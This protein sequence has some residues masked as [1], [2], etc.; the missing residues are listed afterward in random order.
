MA[1]GGYEAASFAI[2]AAW[3]GWRTGWPRP[4]SDEGRH[5]WSRKTALK[6]QQ[7]QRRRRGAHKGAAGVGLAAMM[8]VMVEQV[9]QHVRQDLPLWRAARRPIIQRTRERLVV[10]ARH[11]RDQAGVLDQAGARQFSAILV[12]NGVP[13]VG[14]LAR[15]GQSR[16]G[17]GAWSGLQSTLLFH[18]TLAPVAAPALADR[19]GA[20]GVRSKSA[21]LIH[22]RSRGLDGSV[23]WRNAGEPGA[24][25]EGGIIVDT[26]G[27]ALDAALAGVGVAVTDLAYVQRRLGEGTLRVLSDR[28]VQLSEGLYLVHGERAGRGGAVAAIRKW[29]VETARTSPTATHGPDPA[30]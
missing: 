5:V 3:S 20:S 28:S 1:N 14:V 11:H 8:G 22:A 27:Q 2:G 24:P 23:W 15:A 18:E 6:H 10:I 13:P 25:P 19:L 9:S 30:R 4:G 26:R 12:E 17:L 7:I 29:L 16:Q 21:V